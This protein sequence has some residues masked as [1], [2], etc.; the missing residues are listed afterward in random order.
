[1]RQGGSFVPGRLRDC[2][3]RRTGTAA[4]LPTSPTRSLTGR[5]GLV[6]LICT[7]GACHGTC[8]RPYKKELWVQRPE[9]GFVNLAASTPMLQP[10]AAGATPPS[11]TCQ[12]GGR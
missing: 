6:D 11:A 1:M 4:P 2:R 5:D 3:R 7:K 9:G 12:T 10:H 8:T